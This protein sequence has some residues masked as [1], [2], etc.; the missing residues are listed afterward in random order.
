MA[1]DN[2]SETSA[3]GLKLVFLASGMVIQWWRGSEKQ[4]AF[5]APPIL[6]VLT[7][8]PDEATRSLPGQRGSAELPAIQVLGR[9]DLGE[10]RRPSATR[11]RSRGGRFAVVRGC[12]YVRHVIARR[13]RDDSVQG[14]TRRRQG[15]QKPTL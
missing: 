7:T 11:R 14:E 13:N 6:S 3:S 12:T 1:S 5:S 4:A 2:I 8:K 10:G 15:L 9:S